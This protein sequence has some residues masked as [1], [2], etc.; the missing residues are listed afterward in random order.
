MLEDIRW[1]EFKKPVFHAGKNF[2]EKIEIKRHDGL[3]IQLHEE[4]RRFYITYQN[5]V[6]ELPEESAFSWERVANVEIPMIVNEHKTED[7]N[8]RSKAQVSTPQSN[9]FEGKGQG[10]K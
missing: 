9:V 6:L 8:K 2:T 5:R 4:K 7:K 1:I 10:L 3:K